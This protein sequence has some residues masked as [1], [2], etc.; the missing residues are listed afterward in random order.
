MNFLKNIFGKKD[1]PI[2]N[3]VD[4]WNWFQKN[5]KTFFMS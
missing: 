5:E 2:K 4:F 3:Y 1:E